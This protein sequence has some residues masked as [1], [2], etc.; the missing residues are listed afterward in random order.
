MYYTDKSGPIRDGL[1]KR[2]FLPN[3]GYCV[4]TIASHGTSKKRHSPLDDYFFTSIPYAEW[5]GQ[6]PSG[7]QEA[8]ELKKWVTMAKIGRIDEGHLTKQA[9][10]VFFS[11]LFWSIIFQSKSIRFWNNDTHFD[12]MFATSFHW[13]HVTERTF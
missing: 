3:G 12:E 5:F 6:P 9:I 13:F 8:H 1:E 7:V 4:V 2:L 10:I 11:Q